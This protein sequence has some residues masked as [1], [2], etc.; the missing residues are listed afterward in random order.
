MCLMVGNKVIHRPLSS[1]TFMKTGN[2]FIAAHL[3]LDYIGIIKY[4]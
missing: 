2:S 3:V 1:V 4:I